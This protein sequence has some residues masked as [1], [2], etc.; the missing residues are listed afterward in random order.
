MR[1]VVINECYGGFGLS[2]EAYEKM[3]EYGYEGIEKFDPKECIF[4]IKYYFEVAPERTDIT[5][6]KVIEE[7]GKRANGMCANLKIHEVEGLYRICEYDGNEWIETPDS[8][9]W[10]YAD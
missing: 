6:I 10:N 9:D 4:N 3:I 7:L 5:L 1:K 8:I 2:N